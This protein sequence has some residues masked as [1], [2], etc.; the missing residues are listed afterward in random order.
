VAWRWSHGE[1]EGGG[2]GSWGG[3]KSGE[4]MSARVA[5]CGFVCLC[6]L[7]SAWEGD[8]VT[9]EAARGGRGAGNLVMGSWKLLRPIRPF[10]ATSLYNSCG[11]LGLVSAEKMGPLCDADWVCRWLVQ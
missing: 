6:G 11:G 5:A 10:G 7:C 2:G 3:A 8:L 4:R 9:G 1:R